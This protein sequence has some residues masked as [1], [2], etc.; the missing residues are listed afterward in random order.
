EMPEH[1]KNVDTNQYQP[2]ITNPTET[3][4][5]MLS[6]LTIAS[7]ESI[8]ETYDTQV[9]TNTI[10]APGSDAA[11]VRVRHHDKALAITTDVNGRYLYL[12]P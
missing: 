2:K 7:K 6:Q 10:V 12:N 1:L 3:L 9:Q 5:E 4:K 8:Y 11:V